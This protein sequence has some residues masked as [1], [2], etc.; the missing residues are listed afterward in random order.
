MIPTDRREV[1]RTPPTPS[2]YSIGSIRDFK[3]HCRIN[4]L[5][6]LCIIDLPEDFYI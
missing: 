5:L 1:V 6:L 2:H 4:Y 3:C